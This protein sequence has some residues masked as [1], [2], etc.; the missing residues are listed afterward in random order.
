MAWLYL[1]T[2]LIV[3]GCQNNL[4]SY[5]DTPSLNPQAIQRYE[6]DNGLV[7]LLQPVAG[8]GLVAVEAAVRTGSITE[9]EWMG[10]GISHFVEHMLFKGTERRGVGE[11]EKE[12]Q[13]CGGTYDAF[14]SYEYTGYRIVIPNE[15]LP[16]ILDLLSDVLQNAAFDPSELEKERE[17]ILKELALNRDDPDRFLHLLNWSRAYTDHPY[18][19][20]IIG[21]EPLFRSLT[22]EDVVRY[23]RE[24]YVPN[25][26]VLALAG[27]F[28]TPETAK[29]IHEKF[30]EMKRKGILEVEIPREPLQMSPRENLTESNKV[31]LAHIQMTYHTVSLRDPE[32]YSL[33][34]LAILLGDGES[35]YLHRLLH[36][37]KGLVYQVSCWSY[38]PRDP[39]VFT[40]DC[41]LE[42]D[43]VEP[44]IAET[45]KELKR[46]LA[47]GFTKSDLEKA[48]RSVLTDYFVSRQT[49]ETLAGDLVSNELLTSDPN[50]SQQYVSGIGKVTVEDLRRVLQNYLREDR[51][52]LVGL[53]PFSQQK[54]VNQTAQEEKQSLPLY[55]E[56]MKKRQLSN[57]ITV[58]LKQDK[59]VPLVSI[60]AA[61]K[62]GLTS[63][64]PEQAGIS[65][66]TAQLLVKGTAKQNAEEIAQWIE[67]RGG[68][69]TP[70]SGNNGF[71][72]TLQLMKEDLPEGLMLASEMVAR[73]SFPEKEMD[74]IRSLIQAGIKNQEEDAFQQAG[75]LLKQTLFQTHP[76]R[77]TTLGTSETIAKISRGDL[78]SYYQNFCL[79]QNLTL[80]LVGDIDEKQIES[81][82]R[83]HFEPWK[84]KKE[85]LPFP[86]F[87]EP[88]IEKEREASYSSEKDQ[89]MVLMGFHTVSLFSEERYRFDLLTSILSGGS[90]TLYDAI[91]QKEGL[92]YSVGAY[93]ILGLDTGYYV[94]Y[95]ATAPEE[96]DRVQTLLRQEI[97]ALREHPMDE[98]A[99][100]RAK[101]E[102]IGNNRIEL[103]SIFSLAFKTALNECY[104]LG[105]RIIDQYEQK[106]HQITAMD[107]QKTAQTYFDL[108][109]S[110]MVVVS[111]EKGD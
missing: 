85:K 104:G 102:L 84:G 54:P 111:K 49:V 6:L 62:G 57:G 32:L 70:F 29:I 94:F 47:S 48:K 1:L 27:D 51:M 50:F 2:I 101:Q 22:R 25:N 106:I 61:F 46:L 79:P 9:G 76:F 36:R 13:R 23:Y 5:K 105:Y 12:I 3:S 98:A 77:F 103:Q 33:D 60:V 20:P 95:A 69:L 38:T 39:G 89:A 14:T 30:I 91:R 65:N 100:Q 108:Q 41:L 90:G 99:L 64:K 18:R 40:I 56:G 71:G 11:V 92:A 21:Y 55:T 45:Q 53:I 10:S 97:T 67:E 7:V 74:R 52:T 107:I 15:N 26:M 58:L 63:E 88:A 59:R 8:S 72:F 31:E 16:K 37:E 81:P 68:S 24:R 96:V 19:H 80:C 35:S 93:G 83:F 73:P 34:V 28:Q 86:Q 44:V 66:F 110:V 78:A 17:V 82:I 75:K 42:P 109:K 4:H 87:S 43:K